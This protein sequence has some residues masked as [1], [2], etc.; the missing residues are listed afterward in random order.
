M[1]PKQHSY[2]CDLYLSNG[3]ECD[4]KIGPYYDKSLLQEAIVRHRLV[5]H[6]NELPRMWREQ[7]G[8]ARI[9]QA[10]AEGI[11]ARIEAERETRERGRRHGNAF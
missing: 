9:R 2:S 5:Q 3:A 4:R 7:P 11:H 10:S 8:D 6:A 1:N